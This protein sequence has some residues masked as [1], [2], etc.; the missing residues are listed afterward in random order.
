MWTIVMA[1]ML[2]L[3]TAAA[4]SAQGRCTT[5]WNALFQQYETVCEDGSRGTEKWNP[6]FRQWESE[7]R[8]SWGQPLPLGQSCTTKWN[9]L[10]RQWEREC[11]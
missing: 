7:T 5:K 4:A 11:H 6:L 3:G 8:P 10:F 9:A 1:L 2:S